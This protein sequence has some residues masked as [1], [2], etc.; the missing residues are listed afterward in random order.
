M[1]IVKFSLPQLMVLGMGFVYIL[2]IFRLGNAAKATAGG[3]EAVLL[4]ALLVKMGGNKVQLLLLRKLP[5]IPLWM[6]NISVFFYEY[7]TALLV[8]ML[9]LSVPNVSTAIYLSLLSWS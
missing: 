1:R 8:R 5:K 6:S 2:G 3:L 7:L 9:L 4:L